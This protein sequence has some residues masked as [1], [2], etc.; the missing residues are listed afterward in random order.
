MHIKFEI[1]TRH[2][3]DVKADGKNVPGFKNEVLA[4]DIN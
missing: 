4:G 3:R 2:L 1:L